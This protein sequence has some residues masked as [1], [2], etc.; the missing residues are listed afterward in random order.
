M[1]K[2]NDSGQVLLIVTILL[3]IM[4]GVG[5]S[6]SNQTLSSIFR[7][8]QSDSFQKVTAA[9]E[10]GLEKYLLLSDSELKNLV[11]K[12]DI[13]V[14]F[15]ESKTKAV[16][17]IQ[18]INSESPLIFDEVAVGQVATYYF[19]DDLSN[20]SSFNAFSCIKITFQDDNPSYILNIIEQ[21]PSPQN[22]IP[23]SIDPNYDAT[24]SNE[25][26]MEKYLVKNGSFVDASPVK[27]GD[28]SYSING[29]AMLRIHPL[30]TTLKNIK[31]E[32]VSENLTI[33]LKKVTQGYKIISTGSFS[34]GDDKTLRK[35]TASKFLDS[36][37]NVFDYTGFLD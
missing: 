21:N 24:N 11:G 28:N 23:T 35:I 16:L 3:T 1:P 34:S 19:S 8:S 30:T 31:I 26:K 15:P 14:D 5:L 12:T 4:L 17:S 27:C 37:A 29:A 32:V 13:L 20:K 18:P 7:T 36:P 25:Y 33:D 9:A 10:G 2:I 22:F 6:I